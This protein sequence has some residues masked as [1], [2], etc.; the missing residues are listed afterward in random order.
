VI[1]RRPGGSGRVAAGASLALALTLPVACGRSHGVDVAGQDAG[2]LVSAPSATAPGAPRAGMVW[3]PAGTLHAGSEVDEVPRVA[4]AEPAAVDVPMGGF[5]IDVLPWP[6]ESGAIPTA[7]V[8]RD[9]AARLC[10]EKGKRLCSELEWERACKGPSNTR[11]EYG[12]AYEPRVCGGGAP[13][14]G[15]SLRP[16]GQRVECRSGFGV[17]DMHGGAAEWTDSPWGRGGTR[18]TGVARGGNDTLG[19]LVTRCAFARPLGPGD[20]S[21]TVGFRCCAGPRN[22][23]EVSLAVKKGFPFEYAPTSAHGS[24][25]LDALG[26]V[27]CGPPA[28]PRPCS[29]AR[30]WTWRPAPNVELAVAGGCVGFDPHARCAVAVSRSLGGRVDALAQVDTGLVIPEVVL[31]ESS[32]HRIRVRGADAHGYYFREIVF[33]YGRVDVRNVR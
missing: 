11:Y 27:A 17:R 22:E 2:L 8:T 23:A 3:V 26:G 13:A 20:R 18:D 32:D 24:P 28:A 21:A 4:D 9:E 30:A 31:V 29:Y 19:E 10:Q 14:E 25:P 33:S 1:V 15:A 12:A 6:N 16:S 7:N 5:Y